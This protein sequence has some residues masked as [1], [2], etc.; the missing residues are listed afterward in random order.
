[1]VGWTYFPVSTLP[2]AYEIVWCRFP[3]HTDL[4]NPS[5]KARPALVRTA[6]HD[7]DGHGEVQAV[8]GTTKLKLH[9]RRNDFFITNLSEMDACGLHRATRFDLDTCAWVPWA[10]EWFETLPSY[11]SP[12]IGHLTGHGVRMLQ[13]TL[14]VRQ[15][16]AQRV[17]EQQQGASDKP[18]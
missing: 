11:T 3:D 2:A 16:N 6:S 13:T 7:G 12:I 10:D 14:S 15:R 4:T 18:E 5:P 17:M 1:M 8:Y 9:T